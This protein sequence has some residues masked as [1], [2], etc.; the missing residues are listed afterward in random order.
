MGKFFLAVFFSFL[1]A[2]ISALSLTLQGEIQDDFMAP[3][4]KF[5]QYILTALNIKEIPIHT[6]FTIEGKEEITVIIN[7]LLTYTPI[8]YI[9]ILFLSL[10]SPKR[11]K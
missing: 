8:F 6:F 10:F 1:L 4:L 3:I 11:L 2:K 5:F 7:T 9:T